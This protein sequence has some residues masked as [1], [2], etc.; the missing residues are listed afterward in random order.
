MSRRTLVLLIS[1]VVAFGLVAAAAVFLLMRDTNVLASSPA[2]PSAAMQSLDEPGRKT[3]QLLMDTYRLEQLLNPT[4]IGLILETSRL[5]STASLNTQAQT[6]KAR[7]DVA[8]AAR[9]KVDAHST[10]LALSEQ[11][12]RMQADCTRAGFK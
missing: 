11:A 9:G 10:E 2:S 3:C 12:V 4:A 8:V 6:L 7:H 5:S 1:A